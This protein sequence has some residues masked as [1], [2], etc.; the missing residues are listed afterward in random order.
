M[1]L[2][3]H[4][5]LIEKIIRSLT[6]LLGDLVISVDDPSSFALFR[7]SSGTTGTRKNNQEPLLELELEPS[8]KWAVSLQD[9]QNLLTMRLLCASSR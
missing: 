3:L 6:K 9:T 7:R 2:E 5:I 1:M 4:L 8:R